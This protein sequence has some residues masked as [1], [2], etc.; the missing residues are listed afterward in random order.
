M[1]YRFDALNRMTNTIDNALSATTRYSFDSVGNLATMRYPDSLSVTN[2]WQYDTRNRLTNLLVYS[3]IDGLQSQYGYALDVDGKRT[4]IVEYLVGYTRQ[5]RYCYDT[6]SRMTNEVVTRD[7]LWGITG[8]LG[9]RMD[10]VGNRTNRSGT[11]GQLGA[12]NQTYT[13][14]DW[15]TSDVYDTNGNTRTNGSNVYLYDWA[16]RLTNAVIGSTNVAIIAPH[17]PPCMNDVWKN[18]R[19]AC[20]NSASQ[21]GRTRRVMAT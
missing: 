20:W 5:A 12:T 4:N 18:S 10:V 7:D 6:L 2:T 11:L 9:Y 17:T 16:N 14:N 15:L 8:N 1:S 3:H 21:P 19:N 13:T